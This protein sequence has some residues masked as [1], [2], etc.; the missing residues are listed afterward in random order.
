MSVSCV[1]YLTH[2]L[3]PGL[4]LKHGLIP[5][6]QCRVNAHIK[7]IIFHPQDQSTVVHHTKGFAVYNRNGLEKTADSADLAKAIDRLLYE[8]THSVYVGVAKE[9]LLLLDTDFQVVCECE[10]EGRILDAVVNTWTGEVVTG[11]PGNISVHEHR[12]THHTH[13][14]LTHHITHTHTHTV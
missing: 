1:L 13:T 9:R 10:V 14:S 7:S 4:E 8:E 2:T 3:P 12:G 11:G 6:Y 5:D